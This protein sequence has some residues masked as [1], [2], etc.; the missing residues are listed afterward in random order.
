M[1]SVPVLYK[2]HLSQDITAK[3]ENEPYVLLSVE[4]SESRC[5]G[6]RRRG[7][8]R[9]MYR[10]ADDNLCFDSKTALYL[11][12]ERRAHGSALDEARLATLLLFCN[13]LIH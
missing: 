1:T 8:A 5:Q 4:G 2:D 6:H 12:K 3:G 13:V 9:L 7:D 11:R 10:W